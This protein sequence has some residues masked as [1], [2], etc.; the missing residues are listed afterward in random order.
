MRQ[1]ITIFAVTDQESPT[2]LER[3]V[4]LYILNMKSRKRSFQNNVLNHCYQRTADGGVI[5]YSNLD[6]LVWF[7]IVCTTARKHTVRI[8]AM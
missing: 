6:Y 1:K 8:L 7:T 4:V 2:Q 3:V 5:F